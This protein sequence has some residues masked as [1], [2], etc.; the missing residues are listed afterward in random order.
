[1]GDAYDKMM[2]YTQNYDEAKKKYLTLLNAADEKYKKDEDLEDVELHDITDALFEVEKSTKKM[3]DF[4]Q[5]HL[6][7]VNILV[8]HAET[9]YDQASATSVIDDE[10]I[11]LASEL[12]TIAA[13]GSKA[14]L[15]DYTN[16]AAW[17]KAYYDSAVHCYED[18]K[19]YKTWWNNLLPTLRS[20]LV[21]KAMKA[22]QHAF[23]RNKNTLRK[24]KHKKRKHKNR[25][26]RG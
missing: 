16:K 1:M 2:K 21:W 14:R 10:S 7:D 5:G 3:V 18:A 19:K 17:T 15:S 22:Y 26:A 23:G 11:I 13:D 4:S 24:R 9:E 8:R 12:A 20:G 25:T 6:R